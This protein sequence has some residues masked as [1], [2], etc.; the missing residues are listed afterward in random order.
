MET[1]VYFA[2]ECAGNVIISS[3][4]LFQALRSATIT[5]LPDGIP[6]RIPFVFRGRYRSFLMA[7]LFG[8]SIF[9]VGWQ[10]CERPDDS[11]IIPR[12]P[13]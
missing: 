13:A 5:H 10:P 7:L 12:F 2:D 9:P 6:G 4:F 1:S 8:E 11:I 3:G